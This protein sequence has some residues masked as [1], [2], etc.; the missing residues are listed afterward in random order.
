MRF[1]VSPRAVLAMSSNGEIFSR[2]MYEAYGIGEP[3][4][5]PEPGPRKPAPVPE[6]GHASN[7]QLQSDHA[8][9]HEFHETLK[10]WS[11]A[12]YYNH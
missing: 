11:G 5:E 9:L 10:H 7:N 3:E 2:F 8:D 6:A 4:P 12:Y 1:K